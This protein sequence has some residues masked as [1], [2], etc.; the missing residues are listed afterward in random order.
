MK[1]R[2]HIRPCLAALAACAAFSAAAAWF[3]FP[4]CRGL[5]GAYDAS[6][7]ICD[8]RG[9]LLRVVTSPDGLLCEPVRRERV[10]DW[11][12]MAL[13]AGE[14][15]RF[16]RHS[17]VDLLAV[18]RAAWKNLR[19][20]RIVSGASTISMLVGKL[21]QPRPRTLRTKILEAR[22]ALGLERALDKDALLEQ[23]LNRAPFGGN[24]AG[25]E[26]AARRYFA[27][28]A[29][30]LT[31][32]EAALLVGLPQ[33]PSRLRP[34]L[35]PDRAVRRRDYILEQMRQCGFITGDQFRQA[36]AQEI[37]ISRQ[38]L[39]FLAPHFCDWVAR[40]IPRQP[41]IVTA[42][43][44]ELQALAEKA[45]R[46]RLN[47]LRADGV[48]GGA[49]VILDVKTGGVRALVGSPDYA[50]AADSGQVN[51]ALARR[52]PGSAL[53]PFIYALALDE[54]L[55]SP[56]TVL[57]D[58]PMNFD[59]YRPQ[60]FDRDYRGLVSVRE[61]LVQSLNIPAV[62]LA[63]KVGVGPLVHRLRA[64][65]L[66]TL[67][68]PAD[69]YGLGI[70]IGGCEVTLLELANAYACLARG[71]LWREA[72]CLEQGGAGAAARLFSEEAA[73][74]VADILGG[75]ER[76]ADAMGHIAEVRQPRVAWKTGTSAGNRDAW[77]IAYNPDYV[78][79]VWIGN[80][81][82]RSSRTL[83]GSSAAAPV[84]LGLF[85][86]IYP[87][88]GAPWF[89]RPRRL[90]SRQVCQTSGMPPGEHCPATVAADYIPG[91]TDCARCDVH[92]FVAGHDPSRKGQVREVWPPEVQ[93]FLARPGGEEA[94]PSGKPGAAADPAAAA[95]A[96]RILSPGRGETFRL[97]DDTP[98]FRQELTLRAAG[99]AAADGLYWFVDRRL[100]CK[101]ETGVGVAWSLAQGAHVISCHDS[102]GRG[103]SVTVFVE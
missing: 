71:G 30:D 69:H 65:G 98:A 89:E 85:R 90:A 44:L 82:G 46:A 50:A 33:S 91:I 45:L 81:S 61:A 1:F 97:V 84:A 7:R 58:V 22:R 25:I 23:Y 26:A 48:R 59:G 43:D 66:A 57:A 63:R 29:A 20:G 79:G 62:L 72:A 83:V 100:Y 94:P 76:A 17:G 40:T 78:V 39:P 5:P 102:R 8:R 75:D 67:D 28:S 11:A 24:V 53:K 55:C 99:G 95:P 38:P 4:P 51:G 47:D 88:G 16:Y 54:G 36:S 21:I 32:S 70:A 74:L 52:S 49:I 19:A 2:R 15:K 12:A 80:P 37:R 3:L 87:K 64:A 34:D 31:L 86:N 35:H 56:G 42:L 41:A 14:D 6:T 60:N 92:R 27:K 68:R 96:V 77:C 73:Y 18:G 10:G 13:V 103:D 9:N 101:A 93:A